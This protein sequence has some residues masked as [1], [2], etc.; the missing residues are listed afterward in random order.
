MYKKQESKTPTYPVVELPKNGKLV[1]PDNVVTQI[2]YLHAK[3]GKTEWSGLLLY[4]VISGNPSDPENF[5]L[6]AK[7]I[8]LMDIG[9]SAFTEY[10]LD[11]DIVD[12]YDNVE[13]AMEMK[14]GHVHTHHDMS[15]YFSGTD[16][17]ELQDNVD[18]HNY[19]LSL[20]VNFSSNYKAKVAFLSDVHT[21]SKMS[22]IDDSG[23]KDH[24]K[25]DNISKT[26]ITVDMDI[27]FKYDDKFFYERY[28]KVAEQKKKEEEKKSYTRQS[29]LPEHTG[30]RGKAAIDADPLNMT[31]MEVEILARN[32]LSFSVDLKEQR[33]CY[34]V[35]HMIAESRPEELE[36]YYQF[37]TENVEEVICN[38]FDQVLEIDEM[39]IVVKEIRDSLIRFYNH[40][41]LKSLLDNI[42]L[43]LE[44]FIAVYEKVKTEEDVEEEIEK[45]DL[46]DAVKQMESEII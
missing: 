38:Y 28:E 12:V 41:R 13:G 37:F 5:V 40:V 21:R 29:A 17:S 6:E 7:H 34:Q 11:G 45:D 2:N 26:M 8:F 31:N 1:I 23:K 46:K 10:E 19:Y 18:K 39:K 30:P 24:F 33:S 35:L 43:I 4:D 9:T 14:L 15:A 20:I 42:D 44:E 25:T 32:V 16:T 22:Y 3:I 27:H 36:L